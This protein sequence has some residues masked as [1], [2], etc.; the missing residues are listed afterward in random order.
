MYGIV[1]ATH[2][3]FASGIY[4]GFKLVCGEHSNIRTVEFLEGD[5]TEILDQRLTEAYEAVKEHK[6][7]LFLTDL[8][9]G[10]PF[11]RAVMLYGENPDVRVLSGLSFPLLY[12]ATLINSDDLNEATTIILNEAKTATT[13]YEPKIKEEINSDDGI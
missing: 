4:N 11:N 13:V 3:N 12:M 6:K 8:A 9:G 2:G 1:I 5:T 10:T 7:I